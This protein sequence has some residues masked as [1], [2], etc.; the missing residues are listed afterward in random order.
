MVYYKKIFLILFFSCIL[1]L[2]FN[3]N[4]FAYSFVD[5][6]GNIYETELNPQ[7]YE[8]PCQLVTYYDGYYYF[9][10]PNV[11]NQN[12]WYWFIDNGYLSNSF[13]NDSELPSP[14]IYCARIEE[15]SHIGWSTYS[16]SDNAEYTFYE[17][18]SYNS[19]AIYDFYGS[20]LVVKPSMNLQNYSEFE[21]AI[22]LLQ[23]K[24]PIFSF[25]DIFNTSITFLGIII[26]V[27]FGVFLI[28]YYIK[29][30]GRL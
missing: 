4:V 15:G 20:S 19:S 17:N 29:R 2:L 24:V 10:C 13:L 5:K 12:G 27:V 28:R 14:S 26:F 6:D 9:M 1:L 23:L 21:Q 16:F 30:T 22:E 18:I 7:F 11:P 25:W 8:S 3:N